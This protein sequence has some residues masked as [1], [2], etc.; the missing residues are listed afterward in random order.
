M[1]VAAK[2]FGAMWPLR[3]GKASSGTIDPETIGS[4]ASALLRDSRL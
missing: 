3:L 2:A 1:R 4:A